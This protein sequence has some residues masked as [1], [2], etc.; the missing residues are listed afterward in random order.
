MR[1]QPS[2]T[3]YLKIYSQNFSTKCIQ[4]EVSAGDFNWCFD[5]YFSNGELLVEPPL[6]RALIQDALLRFLIKSDYSLEAGGDYNFTIR[7][8]F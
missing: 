4:G 6:G 7:A 8:K 5:W 2:T 1:R 3:A